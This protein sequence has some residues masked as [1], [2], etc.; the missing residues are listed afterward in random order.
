MS[1]RSAVI[2]EARDVSKTYDRG[3]IHVLRNVNLTVR[4]GEVVGLWGASGSGK[5]TLLHHPPVRS[6]S[7]PATRFLGY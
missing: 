7:R 2:A 5:S 1:A 6:T 4:A 3:R